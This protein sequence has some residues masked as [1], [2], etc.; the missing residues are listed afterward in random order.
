MALIISVIAVLVVA[1]RGGEPASTPA[2]VAD[3][4]AVERVAAVEVVRL[5]ADAVEVARESGKVIGVTVRD[6]KL[7]KKLGLAAGDVIAAI[8]GR[9]IA[10]ELDVYEAIVG[11]GMIDSKELFVEV[12][13]DKQPVLVRWRLEGD[14]RAARRVPDPPIGTLGIPGTLPAPDPVADAVLATIVK[15]DDYNY[16]LPRKS[17]DQVLA[18]PQM[19]RGVRAV[20]SM[21]N[22]K[23]DGIKLYAIRPYS[24]YAALGFT[25]GDTVRAVNGFEIDSVTRAVELFQELKDAKEL[26]FELARRGKPV[27]LTI[28]II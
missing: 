2:V 23:V 1:N 27:E 4:P 22:G 5:R 17:L 21:R 10:G 3:E 12:V 28:T 26:R 19:M 8:S 18:D 15:V 24:P 7:R 11:L 6:D 16:K 25:N 14:L 13:R 20:P 9:A